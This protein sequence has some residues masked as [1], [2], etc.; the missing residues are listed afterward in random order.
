MRPRVPWMTNND[1]A[2]LEF[3]EDHD[4]ALGPRDLHHNL[5]T[6]ENHRISYTHVKRRLNKLLEAD[7]V[8]KEDESAGIYGITDKGREYLAGD[9]DA[10]ELI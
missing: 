6:R 5:E 4:V 2:I 8:Q 10:D 9:L 7:L 1:D 3:F